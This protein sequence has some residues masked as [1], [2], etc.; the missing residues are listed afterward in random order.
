MHKH[1]IRLVASLLAVAVFML[2]AVGSV[3][4]TPEKKAE[5][6]EQSGKKDAIGWASRESSEISTKLASVREELYF[7]QK[8]VRRLSELSEKFPEDASRFAS[9]LS[10]WKSVVD[11]LESAV[12]NL[13]SKAA[14]AYV[15]HEAHGAT[16]GPMLSKIYQDWNPTAE[17]A[18]TV[19]RQ[20]KADYKKM[21]PEE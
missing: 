13:E 6:K 7:A 10:Q 11:I 18:L 16:P 20:R 19:A 17:N 1:R 12:S 9:Q 21:F 2:L 14:K 5:R 4:E 3:D 8:Q 15:E